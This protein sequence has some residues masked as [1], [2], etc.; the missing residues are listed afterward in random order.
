MPDD[1][2]VPRA[3]AF[4]R[5]RLV[6]VERDIEYAVQPRPEGLAQAFTIGATFLGDG[7][8]ALVL[9]DNIDRKSTRLNSSH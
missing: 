6:L 2:H 7:P 9:G 5:A 1:G 8:S 3:M 4:T